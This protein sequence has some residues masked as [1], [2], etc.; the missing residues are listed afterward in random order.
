MQTCVY[1]DNM[2]EFNKQWDHAGTNSHIDLVDGQSQEGSDTF[3][4]DSYELLA[5]GFRSPQTGTPMKSELQILEADTVLSPRSDSL[6][7]QDRDIL[8][9][10]E[11]KAHE[12][13][14]RVRDLEAHVQ[15]LQKQLRTYKDILDRF[16]DICSGVSDGSFAADGVLDSLNAHMNKE[17]RETQ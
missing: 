8:K 7:R 5:P 3:G 11:H 4:S 15:L 13:E 9:T 17:Y 2:R 16:G 1:E 14:V 12:L 10:P 6:T